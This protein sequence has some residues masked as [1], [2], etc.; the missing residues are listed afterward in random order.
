LVLRAAQEL[1]HR[2]ACLRLAL[3]NPDANKVVKEV[4]KAVE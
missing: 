4:Y 1:Q 3:G 2:I